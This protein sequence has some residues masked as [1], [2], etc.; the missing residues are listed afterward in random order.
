MKFFLISVLLLV[1]YSVKCQQPEYFINKWADR[2]PLEKVYLQTDRD[3]YSGGETIWFKAY[4]SSDYF[5]DTISTTLLTDLVNINGQLISRKAWP[6]VYG[7]AKGQFEI[8]DSISSG[9]YILR[10]Y[11]PTMLNHDH[12]FLFSRTI[13][14]VGKSPVIKETGDKKVRMELFPESGNFIAGFPNT[15]SFKITDENGLP[16]NMSGHLMN[17]KGDTITTFNTYHDGMGFFDVIPLANVRYYAVIN[18]DPGQNKYYLPP[19]N[20]E[21][22]VFRLLPAEKGNDFEIYQRWSDT[23]FRAAYI[24]G[25]MQHRTVLRKKLEKSRNDI[26]GFIDTRQLRSGVLHL[27]VF[28]ENGLPLAERLVF[29]NNKE[30]LQ[31]ATLVTD[32]INLSQRGKNRFT[33]SFPDSVAGNFSLAVID[34]D[35]GTGEK[36]ASNII[37]SLL[38][39]SDIRGNIHN[40]AW[41]FTAAPDSAKNGLDLVMMVN[42]WRR[43]RWTEV[44]KM[45]TATPVYRDP[46]FITISG[47]IKI[48]DTKKALSDKELLLM[49][50][51]LQDSVSSSMQM[52]NTDN[53]GSF[54]LDSMIFS[55]TARFLF[56]D[57][58]EK[59]K[60]WLDVKADV[61][62]VRTA[63]MISPADRNKFFSGSS[64]FS[65]KIKNKLAFDYENILKAEG[66]LLTGITVKVRKKSPL[67]ELEEKYVTGMFSGISAKTI[68]LVNTNEKIYQN[69]IFDYIQGRVAGVSVRKDGLNYTLYY[70]QRFSLTGGAIPMTLYLDEMQVDGRLLAT[71]PASQVAM[72]KVYSS[73]F[74]AEGNGV[75][76]V[77]AVYTK[78]G[79]EFSGYSAVSSD[80]I[81]FK[82]YALVKEFYSPD[83]S[84]KAADTKADK[85]ITLLWQPDIIAE[86]RDVQ[87]PV[88]FFNN[89]RT[90]SIKIVAEGMTAD[91]K[92]LYL[93]KIIPGIQKAF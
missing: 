6:V 2:S 32:T 40:P 87:I 43:F 61:D 73:F 71:I 30:Y 11:S 80:A 69:N 8:P 45:A 9:S 14:I 70:R 65:D 1:V 17:S 49:M 10:A 31:T 3:N 12:D 76:G 85:R 46:G 77:L 28:S 52:I 26:T 13:V 74:G 35:Y 83:Y 24:V 38:L 5:P 81:I 4:L 82:G 53:T 18:E 66:Q 60:K 20:A 54:R 58:S 75:G 34:A 67:Q 7:A 23:T 27:T 86:G 39:T 22:I 16:L 42:G 89:D 84:V 44:E 41:Y 64:L 48:R 91:G 59:K 62:S 15:V 36:Q 55:G 29:V 57:I 93:E 25:L 56:S 33:L 37:T 90:E 79:A 92:L 50:S 68:D 78:K 19:A 88:V 51:S 47:Q 72:I 63:Y 21:G